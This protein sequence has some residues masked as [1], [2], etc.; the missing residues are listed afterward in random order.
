M[1]HSLCKTFRHLAVQTLSQIE[2]ARFVGHQPLE[3]TF[4]DINIL[5]LKYRHP[6]EIY[7]QTFSKPQE[8]VNGAD[9]EWWLTDAI[10]SK[11]LGM[12]V[13]AKV[14]NI[15]TNSFL[16]LHYKSGN[17]YQTTKLQNSAAADGLIPMYCLFTDIPPKK[18]E[19]VLL[20]SS[21]SYGCS[22]TTAKHIENLRKKG[23]AIDFASV[24]SQA[25]PW[26]W[27][28]C[29]ISHPQFSSK[30]HTLP[31]IAWSFFQ[32]PARRRRPRKTDQ[33]HET[34][35]QFLSPGIRDE[36]PYHVKAIFNGNAPNET[37]P[38]VRGVLVIRQKHNS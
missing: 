13:Q 11:W 22:L 8:G 17:T 2:R 28:V 5:E 16:H 33:A 32:Q 37:P 26:H 15:K 14:I 34:N 9:W 19:A 7:C 38:G 35:Q 4:T 20:D 25:M 6:T 10:A 24:I 12:R 36:P 31:E 23:N 21:E 3:E 29:L 30:N 1:S 18:S 27:L